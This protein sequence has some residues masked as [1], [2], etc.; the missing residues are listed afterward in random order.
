[1]DPPG[2]ADWSRYTLHDKHDIYARTNCNV[3]FRPRKQWGSGGKVTV[4]GPPE[5]LRWALQEAIDLLARRTG[6]AMQEVVGP[7]HGHIHK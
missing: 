4:H 1:M 2:D 5:N 3:T 7:L 6:S